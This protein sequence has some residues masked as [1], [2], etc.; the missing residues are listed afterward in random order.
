[1]EFRRNRQELIDLKN[2]MKQEDIAKR[3]LEERVADLT[4]KTS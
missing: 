4:S 3:N 2:L 1:M